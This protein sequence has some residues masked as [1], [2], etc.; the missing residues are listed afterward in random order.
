MQLQPYRP[1]FKYMNDI[2]A[3]GILQTEY[4]S[5][6]TGVTKKKWQDKDKR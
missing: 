4:R 6:I 3:Y 1:F 2:N 5:V